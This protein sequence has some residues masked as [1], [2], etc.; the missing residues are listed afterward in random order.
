MSSVAMPGA[1]SPPMSATGSRSERHCIGTWFGAGALIALVIPLVGADLLE[2]HHDLYLLVYFTI[3]GTFLAS[4]AAHQHVDWRA[5]LRTRT[6][7]SIGAGALVAFGIVGKVLSDP[8]ME[9][10]SGAFFW[11]ELAWRGVLYGTMDALLLFVFPAAVAYLLLRDGQRRH[12]LRFAALSLLLSLGITATYH[13]GY[14]QFRG[15]DL[16][17]PEIGAVVAWVP[18]ALTGNPIGAVV[19]HDA[20][21]VAA[22]VHAYGSEVYLPPD[23]DGYAERGSGTA[24]PALAALWVLAAGAVLFVERRRLF[25]S[26]PGS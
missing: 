21:H 18:T 14:P 8:S 2:L 13:L 23:L 16:V 11:F 26:S 9:H 22:N 4:F 17:Q 1:V 6:S 25:P 24:G 5:W 7:W 19:V 15:G 3:A 20:Y 12:Q 10:P